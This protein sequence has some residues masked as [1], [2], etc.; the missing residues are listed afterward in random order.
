MARSSSP[1]SYAGDRTHHVCWPLGGVGAPFLGLAGN[2]GLDRLALRH[3]PDVFG[4]SLAFAALAFPGR[5]ELAR[6]LEGP[7]APWRAFTPGRNTAGGHTGGFHHGLPRL[8]AAT[9]THRFPT[10]NVALSEPGWPL[11]VELDAWSP[12]IP[13]DADASGLPVAVLTWRLRNPG[14]KAVRAV[15]SFHAQRAILRERD[16]W[17]HLEGERLRRTARGF[18]FDHPASEDKP[19]RAGSFLAECDGCLVDAQWFRGGWFDPQ[20]ALWNAIRDARAQERAP[21]PASEDPGNGASLWL[22]LAIPAGGEACARVRLCWYEPESDMR[23]GPDTDLPAGGCGCAPGSA[24]A[25]KPTYRPRYA[26]LFPSVDAVADALHARQDELERRTRACAE[27]LQ[28]HDLPAEAAEAALA[29]LAILR[30]PT[31]LRQHD[32]RLWGWEGCN[33]S[34]G[35]CNGSCTHVWNYAQ[36]LAHLFPEL[37]RSLRET[38]FGESQDERGHQN[39]RSALPI[40]PTDHEFHAA[41]DG[42]F[43]GLVKLWRDWQIS[44][45]DAWLRRMWPAAKRSLEYCIATWDPQGGSN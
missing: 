35:C 23:S 21:R 36:A 5:P 32:G 25:A 18:A 15:F 30:S 16:A 9:F 45:D 38:E 2:G 28:A 12:F 22:P 14:R 11:Q 20:T 4:H 41:A 37:E 27:T 8:T 1:F 17:K 44:G 40:R 39:F 6:V 26:A 33:D 10:A 24:C 34:T 7:V 42:Q 3:K 31:L 19:W 43:G 29:N 13:G